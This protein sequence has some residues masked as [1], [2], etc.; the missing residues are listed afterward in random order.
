MTRLEGIIPANT[1]AVLRAESAD[2]YTFVPSVSYGT[3][4]DGNMLVG[5]EAAD[6]KAES[7][8]EFD[9]VSTGS[10]VLTVKNEKAAFYR[11]ETS[12]ANRKFRVYNNKA[13]LQ[14]PAAGNA[15]AIYFSFD[16]EDATGIIETESE[17]VK[18]QVYDLSGR[19]VRNV[20]KG[21]YIVN[22]NKVL[23]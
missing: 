11:W 8:N 15:R 13:Y 21:I 9:V 4:V 3:P 7:Y 22:G 16:G 10:Y 23:K 5:Y 14:V 19:R 20:Q 2:T 12:D 6:N 18:S 17:N 1:G